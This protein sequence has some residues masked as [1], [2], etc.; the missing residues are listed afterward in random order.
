M[1]ADLKSSPS[2][3]AKQRVEK[4]LAELTEKSDALDLFL[5]TVQFKK[6]SEEQQDLLKI[7][8]N[9]MYVYKGILERRLKIWE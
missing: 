5:L 9:T 8:A 7:Q 6:L 1:E 2:E 4:E 3:L